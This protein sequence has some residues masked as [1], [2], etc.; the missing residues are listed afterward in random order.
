MVLPEPP[1]AV[2][3]SKTGFPFRIFS[4]TEKT[5]PCADA[6]W[7]IAGIVTFVIESSVWYCADRA[8]CFRSANTSLSGVQA[9]AVASPP[10]SL[11]ELSSA[12][13][14]KPF[15]EV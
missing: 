7:M 14:S 13:V 6:F 4:F 11:K 3:T 2:I 5:V 12:G 8:M 15:A 1:W 10:Y 9:A